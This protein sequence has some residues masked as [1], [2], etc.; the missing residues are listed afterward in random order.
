MAVWEDKRIACICSQMPNLTI[1]AANA[2]AAVKQ[3]RLLQADRA[4]LTRSAKE[5]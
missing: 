3:I 1:M 5:S 2:T 4:L